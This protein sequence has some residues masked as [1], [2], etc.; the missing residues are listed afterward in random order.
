M[1]RNDKSIIFLSRTLGMSDLKVKKCVNVLSDPSGP[2]KGETNK[3]VIISV[4]VE[5]YAATEFET[6]IP[7]KL[8]R[9]MLSN[10]PVKSI[11]SFCS[12]SKTLR[13]AC[14]SELFWKDILRRDF[15][16]SYEDA[17][18]I[19]N[20]KKVYKEITP[21]FAYFSKNTLSDKNR[22]KFLDFLTK[23]YKQNMPL[24]I[25][26]FTD[27]FSP[28]LEMAETEP[29]KEITGHFFGLFSDYETRTFYS[30]FE[31]VCG[32]Y[33]MMALIIF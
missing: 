18:M 1:A 2:L 22:K 14:E 7:P 12:T 17:L 4:L 33:F 6:K 31:R 9:L 16:I 5:Y 32:I 3:K 8:H 24:F 26:K 11:I 15:G 20:P 19:D 13:L 28:R 21:I 10:L 29:R 27:I 30:T 25:K 23:L